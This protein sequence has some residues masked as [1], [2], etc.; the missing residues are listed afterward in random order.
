MNMMNGWVILSIVAL[1]FLSMYIYANIFV[2]LQRI[3]E[4]KKRKEE[5]HK[6]ELIKQEKEKKAQI[7]EEKFQ[8]I[9]DRSEEIKR[10]LKRLELLKAEKMKAQKA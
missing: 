10:E 5:L 8:K 1:L 2:F 9:R 4:K 7:R 3:R 6:L